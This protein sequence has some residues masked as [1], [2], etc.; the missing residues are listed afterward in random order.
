MDT[1]DQKISEELESLEKAFEAETISSPIAEITVNTP[2]AQV[3]GGF[4]HTITSLKE[5]D[6]K[7][8]GKIETLKNL[9][10]GEL[11]KLKELKNSIAK[12]IADIKELAETREK[13]KKEI[14]KISGL[15]SEVNSITEEATHELGNI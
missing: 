13:I 3:P 7:I 6:S 4:S 11:D 15:E 8:A 10:K 12:K 14:E 2:K 9:A 1:D 5:T